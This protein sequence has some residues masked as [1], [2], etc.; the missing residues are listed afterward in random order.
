MNGQP[1][2]IKK[3]HID[4]LNERYLTKEATGRLWQEATQAYDL[5]RDPHNPVQLRRLAVALAVHLVHNFKTQVLIREPYQA[6]QGRLPKQL[7]YEA[8]Q[9][10]PPTEE[11]RP[12]SP[13][14]LSLG[15][16]ATLVGKTSDKR[17]G[18]G[19][20][21]ASALAA[22][23]DPYSYCVIDVRC[24]RFLLESH[25]KATFSCS[26]WEFDPHFSTLAKEVVYGK[27]SI[28]RD[29]YE[30]YLTTINSIARRVEATAQRI[31]RTM[32]LLD[33]VAGPRKPPRT[34]WNESASTSI[35]WN[36]ARCSHG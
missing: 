4:L 14:T 19:W 5:S 24:I 27:G 13:S 25:N 3:R 7:R 12:Q 35:A 33:K 16:L 36:K 11:D 28:D 22:L 6:L 26:D 9:P 10:P 17:L 32:W 31:E 8:E 30:A 23:I 1:V 15:D 2:D 21:T 18:F 29:L 34:T 20:P